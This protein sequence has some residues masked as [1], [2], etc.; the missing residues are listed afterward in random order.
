[1]PQR[2]NG[3]NVRIDFNDRIAMVTGAG[4]GIGA[5]IA[6]QFAAAGAR[7]VIADVDGAAAE[8]MAAELAVGDEDRARGIRLDVTDEEAIRSAIRNVENDHGP[9]QVLVSNAGI[10][11]PMATTETP[12]AVWEN[13]LRVN[14]T[15][16][17]LCAKHCLP[18]MRAAGSGRIVTVASFAAKSSP[19]YGDNASYAASK[20]GL[21][22]L[23]HN[24]AV[25]VAGDGITVN[26]IAPGIV[27]TDLLRRAH[28]PQR[29]EELLARLPVG[30]FTTPEEVGALAVFLASDLAGSI[31]GEVVNIN[32]GL[33]FD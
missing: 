6:A 2:L 4:R 11:N 33:Y 20:A 10:S 5:S 24:L 30:R 27:D 1:M 3:K 8:E 23:I 19:I 29:R 9:V 32:G 28:T 25:E 14:L 21:I 18:G 12:L 31:T 13:V 16:A 22:G 26:G 7:V 15:G 17:F